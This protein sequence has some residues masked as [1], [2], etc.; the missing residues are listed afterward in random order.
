M[1]ETVSVYTPDSSLA[2]PRA[3]VVAMFRDLL[4]GRGM[5]WRLALRDVRAQY[6]QAILGVLW[7]FIAPLATT[8][9]WI[10]LS[11]AGIVS[12][13]TTALPYP[14]FVFSGT[15]LWSILV[16][17][18]NSPLQQTNASR[19]MLGKLNFPREAILLSGLFQL[20]FNT[21]IKLVLLLGAL[22]V[23]GINPGWGLLLLPL[24]V[25]SLILVGMAI[26]LLITPVGMLYTDVG[27][28]VPLLMSFVMYLTPVVFPM[29]KEGWV[30]TLYQINPLTPLIVTCRDWLTGT[31]PEFLGYFLGVNVAAAALLFVAWAAWRLAMP[32]IIERMSA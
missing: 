7:A 25:A 1:S 8:I 18:I 2:S 4:K 17:A 21:A 12:L 6:R 19:S 31:S 32:I 3:M 22:L 23:V 15:L 26:G 27:R 10:F 30:A 28:G 11:S 9:T 5:A 14:V 16:D 20:L 13:S 29:P 24:G